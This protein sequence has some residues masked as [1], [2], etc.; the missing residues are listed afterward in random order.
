MTWSIKIEAGALKA[1]K[2]LDKVSRQR[3]ERF[4]DR[5][6]VMRIPVPRELRCKVKTMQV[7]GATESAITV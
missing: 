2:K 1:L 4:I 7:Y 6:R 3:I 5:L